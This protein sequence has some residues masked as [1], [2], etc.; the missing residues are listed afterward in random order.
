MIG[1]K[2]YVA[3]GFDPSPGG[4]TTALRIYDPSSNTWTLGPSSPGAGHSEFYEGAA[5]G[6][7]LY[8]IGGVP[9]DPTLIFDTG[10]N[11]WSLG[12][13]MP[14]ARV[15]LAAATF[16]NSIFV[17]GGRSPQQPPPPDP[18]PCSSAAT[19]QIMRYDIDTN[20][21]SPAG[22]LQ[23]ARSDAT[24][25]RVGGLIYVFGG[26]DGSF[27][28][29]GLE[30]YN[31][32]TMTSTSDPVPMPGGP[33]AALAAGDPQNGSSAN[34]S[35]RIHL[36]GGFNTSG[37][38]PPVDDNHIIYDVDQNTFL[39][40]VPMPTHC[41]PGV[42]RAEHD[43][44][45]GGDRLFA[46]GGACPSNGSSENNLD[47]QMLSGDPPAAS[48]SMTAS[49]CNPSTFP[50]CPL[51]P[52]GSSQV[53]V[54]GTGF[55]PLSAVTLSSSLQGLLPPVMTDVQG[56]FVSIYLDTLCMGQPDSITASSGTTSARVTFTCP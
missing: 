41:D 46:I 24:A 14:T 9:D 3:D 51:Q 23:I 43:L 50:G 19:N 30:I 7:K 35:H 25:A 11:T 53:F 44:V 1:G 6:G 55:A 22:T 47:I 33:R 36:T 34:A 20:T 29:D 38:L 49:S 2:I 4:D 16:G 13:P 17:F 21:W 15:G 10:T 26:C 56:Q 40:G 27:H 54:T 48:A 32:R 28:P 8:C 5:H 37:M 45:F 18:G 31:P 52:A 39:V 42:N 12:T